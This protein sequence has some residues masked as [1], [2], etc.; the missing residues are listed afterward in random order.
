MHGKSHEYQV[1]T[2]NDVND[3]SRVVFER[4]LLKLQLIDAAESI[5]AQEPLDTLNRILFG[6]K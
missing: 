1:N 5:L 2:S 4:V 6:L 3:E